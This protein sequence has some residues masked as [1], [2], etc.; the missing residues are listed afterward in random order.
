[1][2]DDSK[3]NKLFNAYD[4]AHWLLVNERDRRFPVGTLVR[5]RLNPDMVTEVADGSLYADQVNT[6]YGHMSWRYLD[7]ASQQGKDG[8]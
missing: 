3:L 2:T 1:M 5:S 6:A 8:Q 4:K 7:R